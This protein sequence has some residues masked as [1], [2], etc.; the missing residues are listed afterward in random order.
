M[1]IWC[2]FRYNTRY[3]V[4]TVMLSW[5]CHLTP[6]CLYTPYQSHSRP[7]MD[8]TDYLYEEASRD[9]PEGSTGACT[10]PAPPST[11]RRATHP[12]LG[13]AQPQSAELS[14]DLNP[15]CN[16]H[17]AT[18]CMDPSHN[19]VSPRRRSPAT[20]R[21][22][23]FVYVVVVVL[24]LLCRTVDSQTTQS[25]IQMP[26]DQAD[27]EGGSVT[28]PCEVSNLGELQVIWQMQTDDGNTEVLFINDNFFPGPGSGFDHYSVVDNGN[29][30]NLVISGLQ[31]TDDAEFTCLIQSRGDLEGTARVTVKGQSSIYYYN[32]LG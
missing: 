22:R 15:R 17:G 10:C 9:L 31:R 14:P 18:S 28:I 5:P 24:W 20:G 7:Q 3:R 21:L 25:W 12:N 23:E 6:L 19:A 29:G 30:F 11:H 32:S 4:G 1:Y 13:H 8:I 2:L 16:P 27:V 26:T